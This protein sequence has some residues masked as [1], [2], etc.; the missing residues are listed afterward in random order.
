MDAFLYKKEIEN[1]EVLDLRITPVIR[2]LKLKSEQGTVP[3]GAVLARNNSGEV[4]LHK[5]Y[6]AV[7]LTGAV[8]ATNK[9]FTHDGAS[10]DAELSP[11][12]VKVVHGDQ[13]LVDDGCGRL[14]GDGAGTINYVT[15]AITVTLTD[16]PAEDSGAPTVIAKT[17]PI[18]VALRS[19]DTSL[20]EGDEVINDAVS[21]VVFGTVVRDRV[22]VSGEVLSDADE[23]LLLKAGIFALS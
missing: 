15:G 11:R 18:A 23:A 1:A 13:E 5:Q 21:A 12:T 8:N 4:V 3:K 16:A 22:S 2:T 19:A 10:F 14:Y 6:A 17:V 7:D 9:A 20:N